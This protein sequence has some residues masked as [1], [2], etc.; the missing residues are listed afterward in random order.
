MFGQKKT[1]QSEQPDK[2]PYT[3]FHP[4]SKPE[5][6]REWNQGYY[7]VVSIDPSL[8]NFGFRIERRHV[9][10]LIVPIAYSRTNFY[11]EGTAQRKKKNEETEV[12]K[13]KRSNDIMK[14][15]PAINEIYNRVTQFLDG[16]YQQFLESHIF[17]I[18]RQLPHNYQAVRV[19]QHVISY[20]S[21]YL[22]DTPLLP[23]IVEIDSKV[24][25]RALGCPKGIEG[26]Q[27]KQWLIEKANELLTQRG[28]T[29]S[30]TLLQTSSKK[31]DL[32]DVVCQVEAWFSLVGLPL[33]ENVL[34]IKITTNS[35][36]EKP[37]EKPIVKT[38]EKNTNKLVSLAN[39]L[40]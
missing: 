10:G 27:N 38:L 37:I 23:M 22:R 18:E 1:S 29:A 21:L 8:K 34:S 17:I 35:E 12:K 39:Q 40:S 4:H 14:V 24:K 30:L 11:P 28:D 33:T 9:A 5:E 26:R 25:S 6:S 36:K 2:T 31:D 32:A 16:Y 20:L 13:T 7:Q 15:P 19:S 3:I